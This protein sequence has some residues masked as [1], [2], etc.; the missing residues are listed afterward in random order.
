MVEHST[1]ENVRFEWTIDLP[2][3]DAGSYHAV[4][5]DVSPWEFEL[6]IDFSSADARA[7]EDIRSPH[8]ELS[9]FTA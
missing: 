4:A 1:G 5:A 9:H 7:A 6:G 8:R 2:P 3:A